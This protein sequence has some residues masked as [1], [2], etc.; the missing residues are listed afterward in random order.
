L[1]AETLS[2]VRHT[3]VFAVWV[4]LAVS[5]F[6]VLVC[7]TWLLSTTYEDTTTVVGPNGEVIRQETDRDYGALLLPGAFLAVSSVCLVSS[8][9]A[10]IGIRRQRADTAV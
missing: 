9:I 10:L 5:A 4:L 7:I 2:G 1:T 8:V 3:K 6:L